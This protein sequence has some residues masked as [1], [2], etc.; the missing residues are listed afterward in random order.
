MPIDAGAQV[1]MD[2]FVLGISFLFGAALL[3][4]FVSWMRSM[5]G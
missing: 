3:L 4:G 5:I 2:G 1:M